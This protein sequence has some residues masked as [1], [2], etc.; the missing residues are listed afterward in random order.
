[1]QQIVKRFTLCIKYSAFFL[2]DNIMYLQKNKNIKACGNCMAYQNCSETFT[3]MA[4]YLSTLLQNGEITNDTFQAL[5]RQ[6]F[7]F[8]IEAK[9]SRQ[10]DK[11]SET[12]DSILR[13]KTSLN[14]LTGLL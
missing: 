4:K 3:S 5:I 11:I 8:F 13:S 6:A 10:V 2:G 7:A 1:M 12:F 14:R 9:V